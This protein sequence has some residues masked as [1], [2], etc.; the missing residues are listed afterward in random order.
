[1]PFDMGTAVGY[2]DLDTKGF[3]GGLKRAQEQLKTFTDNTSTTSQ[4]W[5]AL[6]S[7]LTTIGGGLA[8]GITT[9]L[10]GVGTAAVVAG[11]SFEAQMSRVEAISE[12]TADEMEALRDQAIQLGADTSFSA[13]EVATAMEN[14]ASAGFGVNEIMDAMPGL[15]DLAASSGA[16]LG[17]ASSYVATTMNAFGIEAENTTHIADVFAQ[18]AAATNAQTEDMGEAMKYIAP[19]A[20]A[21]G[22][23][24]EETAASIGVLSNAGIA[25]SQAGTTLRSMLSSM[26]RQSEPAAEAMER[27]GISF[28]DADGNMKPFSENIAGLQT[29]MQ[30][31]TSEQRNNALVTIFGQE[32]LSGVLALMEAGPDEIDQLTSALENSDGAAQNMADTMQGNT[33]S[34][35]E[36]MFGAF[37]SASIVIQEK[38]APFITNVANKI[39]DLVTKFSQ[40]DDDTLELILQIAGIAAAAGPV[41]L[42]FGN[43]AKAVGN[44]IT[45]FKAI[46][47]FIGPLVSGLGTVVTAFSSIHSVAGLFTVLQ[48][49]VTTAMSGIVSALAAIAGPVTAVIAIIAALVIAWQTDFNGMRDTVSNCMATIQSIIQNVT[50]IVQTI[51]TTVLNFITTAWQT[52]F[53]NIQ[54]ITTAVFNTIQVFIQDAL[55]IIDDIFAIFAALFSGDWENLW[56]NV[57]NLIAD[58]LTLIGNLFMNALNFIVQTLLGWVGGFLDVVMTIGTNLWDTLKNIGADIMEW[59]ELFLQDPVQ[60]VKNIGDALFSA[61][62]EIFTKLWDGLKG[63]WDQISGWVEDAVNWLVDKLNFWNSASSQMSGNTASGSSQGSYASGLDYVPRD[64]LVKVHEGEAILTKEENRN[65]GLNESITIEVP[66]YVDGKKFAHATAKY[67]DKELGKLR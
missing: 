32:A 5:S 25:G 37:E 58:V 42:V 45:V 51:V 64:M 49:G 35:I 30:G 62:A 26:T 19:V 36:Q 22:L 2:L 44:V 47:T 60:A 3:T 6:G 66:L 27:L 17:D 8:K 11:N 12:A 39:A 7:T 1:M 28:Y 43:I 34:A 67:V 61:G 55:N 13:S 29:A 20:N 65:R 21:M 48:Y 14:L 50:T 63:V 59:F 46:T 38:L 56:E 57:K 9:P 23:S 24:L 16:S 53:F 52:N 41:L 18:A 15:L 33:A 31:L 54:G 40:L 4:K 10:L